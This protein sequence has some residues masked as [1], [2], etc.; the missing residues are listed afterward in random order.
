MVPGLLLVPLA[1]LGDGDAVGR[2]L[3]FAPILIGLVLGYVHAPA[4]VQPGRPMYATSATIA[5]QALLITALVV[6][7]VVGAEVLGGFALV[8]EVPPLF[9]VLFFVACLWTVA[10]QIAVLRRAKSIR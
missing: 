2:A 3:A 5:V 10:V 7:S 1:V 9:V 6:Y 4:A 8:I